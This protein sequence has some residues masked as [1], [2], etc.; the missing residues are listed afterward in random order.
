[1]VLFGLSA[2]GCT[3]TGDG[4]GP[5]AS[6]SQSSTAPSSQVTEGGDSSQSGGPAAS[7][8]TASGGGGER[9]QRRDDARPRLLDAS[10]LDEVLRDTYDAGVLNSESSAWPTFLCDYNSASQGETA[11]TI[12]VTEPGGPGLDDQRPT[13][14]PYQDVTNVDIAGADAA[15][16]AN[17]GAIVV[18]QVGEYTIAILNYAK[19]GADP[20]GT[21]A[22]LAALAVERAGGGA[23]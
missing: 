18:A 4:S 21:T 22:Q 7:G 17:G 9:E 6:A 20:D 8:Q 12:A 14:E 23:G 1:M 13:Y 3:A 10:D 11:V 2:A 16:S 5:D 15:F 19:W